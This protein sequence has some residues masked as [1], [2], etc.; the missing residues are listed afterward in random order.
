M[1]L[2]DVVIFKK[3]IKKGFN[4]SSLYGRNREEYQML[5]LQFSYLY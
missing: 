3:E 5:I 4:S 1:F 2:M